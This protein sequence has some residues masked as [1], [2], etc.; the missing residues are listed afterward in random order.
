MDTDATER[1]A[2]DLYAQKKRKGK[3]LSEGS[4]WARVR[5]SDLTTP[6]TIDIA[7]EVCP[8][9]KVIP[10]TCA[11]AAK[12]ESLPPELKNLSLGDRALE[13]YVDKEKEKEKKLIV[14]KV[15]DKTHPGEPSSCSSDD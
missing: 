13:P 2:R 10:T 12:G 11:D 8:Q 5:I 7:L 9:A 14:M 1:L 3:A 4:K 6:T 15:D